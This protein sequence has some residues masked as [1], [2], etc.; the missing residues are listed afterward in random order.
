MLS[1][2]RRAR[3][4]Q[5]YDELECV[6]DGGA[7]PPHLSHASQFTRVLEAGH[8]D[9]LIQV[10]QCAGPAVA[11]PRTFWT[12]RSTHLPLLCA[13]R[14][15]LKEESGPGAFGREEREGH[16]AAGGR[17]C[18]CGEAEAPCAA[19]QL[20]VRTATDTQRANAQKHNV[21]ML[22]MAQISHQV[23]RALSTR[24]GRRP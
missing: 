20:G 18:V 1:H 17:R 9:L 7:Y 5:L 22:E 10:S 11:T 4:T 16:V 12:R 8:C 19:R 6:G 2:V 13:P 24:G 23:R 21:H 15:R 14:R 3:A